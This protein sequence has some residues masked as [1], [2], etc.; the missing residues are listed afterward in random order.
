MP[1]RPDSESLVRYVVGTH[2]HDRR[3]WSLCHVA[4]SAI[5]RGC[6][7]DLGRHLLRHDQRVFH[8][9]AMSSIIQMASLLF[10]PSRALAIIDGIGR[11][12][13]RAQK[14]H[15]RPQKRRGRFERPRVTALFCVMFWLRGQ[16]LNLRPLG[17]EGT[18][19][20]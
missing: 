15:S 2:I 6:D 11:F 13:E 3:W 7:C 16:D 14:G 18:L 5:G 1:A 19:N 17:Y 10:G 12:Q 9:L 4:A 20:R 8:T